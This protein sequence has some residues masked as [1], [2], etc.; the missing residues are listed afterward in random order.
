MTDIMTSYAPKS[1]AIYRFGQLFRERKTKV[2]D[3]DFPALSVTKKG[4]MPQI[5][6]A[7]K[8]DDG[9]NRK[10]VLAGDYVINSRSDR[11]G[12]GGVS[13][14]DGSVS[15]ISIVL[16]PNGIHPRFA[17]H[18][19]R[20][21]AFQEEFYRWGHGIVA[22]LWTTRFADMKNIRVA[23][24]DL[25][26]QKQI[27]S[28]LD[29]EVASIDR[30]IERKSDLLAN[31][32]DAQVSLVNSQIEGWI[33][34]GNEDWKK[35]KFKYLFQRVSRPTKVDDD[36]ITAFRDGQVTLRAKRRSAGYTFADKESGYQGIEPGDLVI[37]AMDGF[38]GAIGVSDSR[39][40]GSPVLSVLT[41][42]N[43]SEVYPPFWAHYLRNLAHTGYIASLSKGIRERS[44]DFR[45]RDAA[46]LSVMCPS[47]RKQ[48]EIAF[49]LDEQ[50]AK[51]KEIHQ[52]TKTSIEALKEYR[53]SLIAAAVTGQ[54]DVKT[55]E[56]DKANPYQPAAEFSEVLA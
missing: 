24:P 50:L 27:S 5:E 52:K 40:K 25:I 21:Q 48:Q 15:L 29:R 28:F 19:L 39:G 46:N 3:A 47:A 10:L 12:S 14:L 7:A 42:Q 8:T 38:A 51:H 32:K 13:D 37:H 6:T 26:D 1:W 9:D 34:Q 2:S 16:Q 31:L 22:D 35:T 23:L 33:E 11:K 20:S 17:H 41:P 44:T 55:W 45:W 53:T 43:A 30:L 4:I 56:N 18:L 49:L 36:V 54:I